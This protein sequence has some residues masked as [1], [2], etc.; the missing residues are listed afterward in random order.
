MTITEVFPH[1]TV[2]QVVFQ[3]RF[4]NLFSMESKI[5]DLQTRIMK[6]FPESALLLRRQVVWADIGPG[7]KLENFPDEASD[8]SSRRIW[9]FKSK[10]GVELN[11][12]TNALDISSLTHKT[13]SNPTADS[14][15]SDTIEFVMGAFLAVTQVP[16]FARIGLRYV[17]ECPIPALESERFKEY[18][19][20][21]FPLDRFR[22]EDATELLSR[23]TVKRGDYFVRYVELIQVLPEGNKYI[24]DFDGFGGNIESDKFLQTTDQLHTLISEEY[25][26]TLKGPALN[27]MRTGHLE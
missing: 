4:P 13:Y 14:R 27:Y 3:V 20:T 10:D 24:L 7:G 11:I 21:T 2:K 23:F 8:E 26:K 17:D 6:R 19:S 15:F 16:L 5:G 9:Q 1:P 25:E 22:L 12:L 18:Y